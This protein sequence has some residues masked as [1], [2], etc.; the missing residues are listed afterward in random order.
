[1]FVTIVGAVTITYTIYNLYKL[2]YVKK[3]MYNGGQVAR[4]WMV[5][6]EGHLNRTPEREV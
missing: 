4:A 3:V 2:Q 6:N 1:M 5:P